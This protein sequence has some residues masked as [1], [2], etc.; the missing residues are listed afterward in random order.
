[1]Q[2]YGLRIGDVGVEF[3][4]IEDRN[5]ALSAFTK[6]TDV[7]IHI[8]GI[9]FTDGEGNFSVYDRD[10]KE[11]L[12]ICTECKG[13]FLQE[14]CSKREFPYKYSY[15]S[16]WDTMDEFICDACFAK[17]LKAKEKADAQKVLDAE[18]D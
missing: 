12:T 3:P 13:T 14:T 2:K 16:S 6:G 17:L 11:V 1:M 15:S 4:S 10:T 5:K 18:E 7:K 8:S 9:K